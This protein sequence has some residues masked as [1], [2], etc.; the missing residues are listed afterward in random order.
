M[1]LFRDITMTR[2]NPRRRL[3]P[4]LL[5]LSALLLLPAFARA[6][7]RD[8]ANI[9]SPDAVQKAN[10][11][12]AQ[13]QQRHNK[14]FIVETFPSIPDDQ[15]DAYQQ[16]VQQDPTTGKAKFFRQWMGSRARAVQA[17]GVF[18]LVNMDPRHIEVGAGQ[19]TRN[20][21][22]FTDADITRLRQ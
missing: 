16:A 17:N 12:M 21:G 9:F 1:K 5:M 13:M 19:N 3:F 18:A 7:V 22:D 11:A 10:A 4:A 14:S 20:S 15:K 8:N 6:D 2:P